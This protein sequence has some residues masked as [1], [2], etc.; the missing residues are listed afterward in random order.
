RL[1][2]HGRRL[3]AHGRPLN[4][5]PERSDVAR[6]AVP[7]AET[8]RPATADGGSSRAKLVGRFELIKWALPAAMAR[9]MGSVPTAFAMRSS[10][11]SPAETA[12]AARGDPHRVATPYPLRS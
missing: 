7:D 4:A 2:A 9:R 3:N 1:N 5:H 12:M 8:Y 6:V 11:N 10:K